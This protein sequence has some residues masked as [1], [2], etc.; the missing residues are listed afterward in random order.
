MPAPSSNVGAPPPAVPADGAPSPSEAEAPPTEPAPPTPDLD[1]EDSADRAAEERAEA[2]R[3]RRLQ[4]QRLLAAE[5]A[6]DEHD[7]P[8]FGRELAEVAAPGMAFD[9]A[10][11]LDRSERVTNVQAWSTTRTV[12]VQTSTS[13]GFSSIS[14]TELGTSGTDVSFLGSRGV[15]NLFGYVRRQTVVLRC[16]GRRRRDPLARGALLH[17]GVR[18]P[19]GFSGLDR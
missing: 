2:H 9:R 16:H 15:S 19:G 13:N 14:T 17:V 10:S 5:E 7:A 12:E 1:E 8:D 4:R 6:R 11:F 3:K 18:L